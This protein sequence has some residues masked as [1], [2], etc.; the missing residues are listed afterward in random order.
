MTKNGDYTCCEAS[1]ALLLPAGNQGIALYLGS[2]G[3][4]RRIRSEIVH[5]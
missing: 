1:L 4:V 5:R 3:S 2:H